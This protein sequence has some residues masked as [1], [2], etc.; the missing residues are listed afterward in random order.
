MG[1]NK[2]SPLRWSNRGPKTALSSWLAAD[3]CKW[4][5][6]W[7]LKDLDIFFNILK[8]VLVRVCATLIY[9]LW[10]FCKPKNHDRLK[11][12]SYYSCSIRTR[13]SHREI[14]KEKLQLVRVRL[15]DSTKHQG[16]TSTHVW[17]PI[18]AHD[19]KSLKHRRA[20]PKERWM[21]G[22]MPRNESPSG[23]VII[24]ATSWHD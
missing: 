13:Y 11:P 23:L 17:I 24:Q 2:F 1:F 15:D 4:R 14:T 12:P 8:C 6:L 20:A 16:S 5:R 3:G 7:H 10:P 21:D 19:N 18:W 22:W 9:A